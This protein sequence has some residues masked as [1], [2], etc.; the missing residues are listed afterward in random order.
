MSKHITHY[1][2]FNVRFQ[3]CFLD[4]D[5]HST[6][7]FSRVISAPRFSVSVSSSMSSHY[8]YSVRDRVLEDI[9]L[10]VVDS[11]LDFEKT[12]FDFRFIFE[13]LDYSFRSKDLI[14]G[15][16]FRGTSKF[17]FDR[18]RYFGDPDRPASS[19]PA[20]VCAIVRFSVSHVDSK[21]V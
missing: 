3:V 7:C 15:L 11:I 19:V 9:R 14:S 1:A 4:P 2:T 17:M 18:L 5:Y 6:Y 20:E 21:G 13:Q 12:A 16:L 10:S 8:N